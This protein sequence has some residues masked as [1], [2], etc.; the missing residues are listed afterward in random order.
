M[1]FKMKGWNNPTDPP[2]R[3]KKEEIT[4]DLKELKKE[5]A[6]HTDKTV[7]KKLNEALKSNKEQL[8]KLNTTN[9]K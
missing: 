8:A 4:H 9:S 5:I 3:S 6:K 2:G 7:L 1:V